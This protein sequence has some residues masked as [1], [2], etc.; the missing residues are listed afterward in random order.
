MFHINSSPE[1]FKRS[2]PYNH[3]VIDNILPLDMS[4]RNFSVI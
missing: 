2:L 4:N 1:E 3:C